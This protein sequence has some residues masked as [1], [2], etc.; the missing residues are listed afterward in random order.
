MHM[1]EPVT[2]ERDCEVILIPDGYAITVLNGTRGHI[3]QVLGGNWTVQLDTGRLVRVSSIDGDALGKDVGGVDDAIDEDVTVDEELVWGRL[4]QCFD[5]EIPVN[6]VDLG[7]VYR[8]AIEDLEEGKK[9]VMVE[10]TLTAPGCGMGQV[11]ADDVEATVRAIP[12]VEQV[13]VDVVFDPP[14][15]PDLMTEEARLELGMF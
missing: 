9:S 15:S 13:Q 3:T 10:M 14:W 1:M 11:L 12:G 2:F 4:R 6:I 8:L 5:P 7:L